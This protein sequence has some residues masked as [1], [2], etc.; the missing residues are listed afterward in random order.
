MKGEASEDQDYKLALL[1]L[2]T[3]DA[4]QRLRE[5]ELSQ[6]D[7]S[8]RQSSVLFSIQALGDRARPTELAYR[9]FREYHTIDVILKRMEK[10]GLVTKVK[11]QHGK[12]SVRIAR[13]VKGKRI[14]QQ[15]TKRESLHQ[16]MSCL[17]D[18]EREQL[19]TCLE[20]LR[21]AAFQGLGMHRKPP[22][23]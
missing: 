21:D 20:K 23:P 19:W 1:L 9:M 13:T 16:V 4:M 17:S 18:I 6:Y 8:T 2:Q 10:D 12:N 7:V 5:K 14:Y 11:D 22:F 3:R 15:S